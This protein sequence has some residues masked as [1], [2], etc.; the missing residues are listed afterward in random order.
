MAKLCQPRRPARSASPAPPQA[1]GRL[2]HSSSHRA[3]LAGGG[4]GSER[5][6]QPPPRLDRS[7]GPAARGEVRCGEGRS[8]AER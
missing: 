5:G 7:S 6:D 4:G 2:P 8:G 1:A 3:R